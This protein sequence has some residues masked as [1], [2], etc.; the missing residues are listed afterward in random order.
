MKHFN[1]VVALSFV[2][3]GGVSENVTVESTSASLVTCQTPAQLDTDLTNASQDDIISLSGINPINCPEI[4]MAQTWAGGKYIFSD[5]PEKPAIR[6]KLYEDGTLVATS[7]TD[8][9]RIFAYHVNGKASGKMKFTVL[10]KNTGSSSGTLTTQKKGVSGPTTSYLYAGKLGFKRWLDSVA[11]SG[12]N[13]AAGSTVQLDTSFEVLS[14]PN[15]LM[16]GIWDYSMTQPHQVTICALDQNDT[17]LTVCPTLSIL[18]RDVNHQRGTFPNADKVYDTSSGIQISTVDGIQQFPLAGN[19]ANDPNAVGTDVT[20]GSPQTLAGNY[21]ILYKMH[22]NT[23]STD[24]QNLG[25]LF[26]PRGGAWGGAVWPVAGIT[27]G[28]KFLIPELTTSVSD[29]TKGAVEGK[30]SPGSG[31]FTAWAQWMPTGGSSLP[32]RFVGVP[33]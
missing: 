23:I 24:G 13:V 26:N 12:V 22:L 27:P 4:P 2:S 3:C 16:H 18:T 1:V 10:I 21:G 6:G 19:T 28:G 31:G 29:N 5:S 25:F 17:P 7:G 11:G 30:Y 9:N 33:F 15:N 14:N 32:L 8:Y 20:D